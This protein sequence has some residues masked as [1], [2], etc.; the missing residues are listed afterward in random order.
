MSA[1]DLAHFHCPPG[2]RLILEVTGLADKVTSVCVGHARSRFVVA[3]MPV[4]PETSRE[5]FY[6]LLYPDNTVIVRYLHEGTVVGFTARLI[7]S[8]QIPFPL[9]FLTFPK[10]LESHDLRRHQRVSCCL[11]GQA[12]IG[13]TGVAG[14]VLDLSHSGCL[15]SASVPKTPPPV[16][17]DD[18]V[19]LR[20]DIFGQTEPAGLAGVVKRVAIS[21]R[22]LELGLKFSQMP[23]PTQEAIKTY[24]DQALSI[25]G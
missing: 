10:R 14:M 18:A 4:L 7:K 17:I 19:L 3:Q 5:S 22:R 11:P 6:Q 24:L 15:F 20:C 23:P 12:V 16:A 2:T 13:G 9:I 1:P 21:G 25:L 8:I